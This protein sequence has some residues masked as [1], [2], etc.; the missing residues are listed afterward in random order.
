VDNHSD[1]F[2][3]DV[4]LSNI[5][6]DASVKKNINSN[7]KTSQLVNQLFADTA[8]TPRILI[9]LQ[10][11]K[12]SFPNI[13]NTMIG[14]CCTGV[15]KNFIWLNP[16]DATVNSV[17]DN[18][19]GWSSVRDRA[20]S[21]G[22]FDKMFPYDDDKLPVSGEL[23]CDNCNTKAYG[24]YNS[25]G[26]IKRL[27]DQPLLASIENNFILDIDLDFFFR[28]TNKGCSANRCTNHL[29]LM[30]E[31]IDWLVSFLKKLKEADKIPSIINFVYSSYNCSQ[32]VC[33]RP[34]SEWSLA[35]SD[36][37]NIFTPQCY[38]LF[39]AYELKKEL[40][41]LYGLK[42]IFPYSNDQLMI[43]K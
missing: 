17:C 22:G 42:E 7:N 33:Q 13:N 2:G 15:S 5:I 10:G 41:K 11:I 40:L 9:K 29:G 14:A 1:C 39:C 35:H 19:K 37:V 36:N 23:V 20:V 24:V 18:I 3:P 16:G 4:E 34:T 12:D 27:I 31:R 30:L 6:N 43:Y 21:G 28:S 25:D 26:T 38:A 32:G 8:K